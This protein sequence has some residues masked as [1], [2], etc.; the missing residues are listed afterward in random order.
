MQ[1]VAQG[2][3]SR[4]AQGDIIIVPGTTPLTAPVEDA[5]RAAFLSAGT[6]MKLNTYYAPTSQQVK[7]NWYFISMAGFDQLNASGNW[8]LED[9][10]AWFGLV[11][12]TRSPNGTWSGAV[13]GTPEYAALLKRVPQ[14]VLS[15][16]ARLNLDPA[17]RQSAAPQVLR[18][19]WQ[20]G[21]SMMYGVKSVHEGGFAILGT[22]KAV[23]LLSD[24][25]ISAGHAPNKLLAA[26]SGS[27]DYVCDD[28]TSLAIRIDDL[29]YVHLLR[30]P[31]LRSAIP[32]PKAR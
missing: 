9:G 10:Q 7:G 18:F 27:I 21:T 28:G 24:G 8:S 14:G 19:P 6:R 4:T 31:N 5:V 1:A 11:L 13:E 3:T 25:D 29:L 20:S 17:F 32:S 12:V 26:T 30:N 22:Y 16:S 23:D 2:I 15:P